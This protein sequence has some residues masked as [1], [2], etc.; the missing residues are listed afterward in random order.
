V[1]DTARTANAELVRRGYEAFNRGDIDA[2]LELFDP[3]V[4]LGVLE[5]SPIAES[6]H[7]HDGFR[8][9]IAE[10]NDMFDQ[11]RSRP[12]EILEP[13]EDKIVVVVRSAARGRLSGAEVEGRV[14]H[15]W[16]IRDRKVVRM[17]VFNSREE[18]L[19]AAAA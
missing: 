12:E 11:Y 5:D 19:R 15:V 2:V 13:S 17:Q 4:E 1:V 14:V 9:M 10:N 8:K 18:A 7:G 6:F 16:T 3:D